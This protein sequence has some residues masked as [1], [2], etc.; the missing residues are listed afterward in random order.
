MG[1]EEEE[2]EEGVEFRGRAETSETDGRERR[3]IGAMNGLEVV[4]REGEAEDVIEKDDEERSGRDEETKGTEEEAEGS[5]D[6][7]RRDRL[8]MSLGVENGRR[9]EGTTGVEATAG[10]ERGISRETD[11]E[12]EEEAG[13]GARG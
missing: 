11:I 10:Y 7:R 6:K 2:E 1:N 4:E 8:S 5:V 3:G 9:V 12:P 13:A